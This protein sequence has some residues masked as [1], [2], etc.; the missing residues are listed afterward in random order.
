MDKE[1]HNWKKIVEIEPDELDIEWLNHSKYF[2]DAYEECMQE[3]K[4]LS[5]LKN[6]LELLE[7]Q[8]T[9]EAKQE[10]P[11]RTVAQVNAYVVMDAKVQELKRKIN[12]TEYNVGL[13]KGL[14]KVFEHR[15]KALE[16]YTQLV[17]S[18]WRGSIPKAEPEV[19]DEM[20]K[21]A[22]VRKIKAAQ[23]NKVK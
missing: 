13:L 8:L 2:F 4:Y 18:G 1:Q 7:A 17:L 9:E 10:D 16:S 15:K 3:E 19:V 11:K 5:D 6:K 22:T 14:L 21:K 20:E 12:E 23:R